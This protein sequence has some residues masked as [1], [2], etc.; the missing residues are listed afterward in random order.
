MKR[1]PFIPLSLVVSGAVSAALAATLLAPGATPK[2]LLL[3]TNNQTLGHKVASILAPAPADSYYIAGYDERGYGALP[4]GSISQIQSKINYK[5]QFQAAK[6]RVVIV[7]HW[8]SAATASY[9]QIKAA[10]RSYAK[11]SYQVTEVH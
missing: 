5:P 9:S 8:G 1:R 7:L 2:A 4:L 11:D 10:L 6:W 3:D